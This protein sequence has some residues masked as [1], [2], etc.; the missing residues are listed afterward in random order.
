M[1]SASTFQQRLAMFLI[2]FVVRIE[3]A[4]SRHTTVPCCVHLKCVLASA[5]NSGSNTRFEKKFESNVIGLHKQERF[6]QFHIWEWG[7]QNREA[8]REA[9]ILRRVS[10]PQLQSVQG[11]ALPTE[12]PRPVIRPRRLDPPDML[13]CAKGNS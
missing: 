11:N 12:L 4:G 5:A 6:W 9:D 10:N 1:A 7:Q 8:D 2:F 3:Q 13:T